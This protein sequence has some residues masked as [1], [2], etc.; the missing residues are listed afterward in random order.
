V[1]LSQYC[2]INLHFT[3]EWWDL[4]IVQNTVPSFLRCTLY[5]ANYLCP[6]ISLYR[7]SVMSSCISTNCTTLREE[8]VHCCSVQGL[9]RQYVP[10]EIALCTLLLIVCNN[11]PELLNIASSIR[12]SMNRCVADKLGPPDVTKTPN[13]TD[14]LTSVVYHTQATADR[15]SLTGPGQ[16]FGLSSW[17]WRQ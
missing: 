5:K 2:T 17:W 12:L 15:S 1:H 16:S 9:Y 14:Q 11:L 10:T 13:K 7:V 4:S 3:P 8:C 6:G